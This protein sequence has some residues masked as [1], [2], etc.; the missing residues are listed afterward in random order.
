[1]LIFCYSH[2]ICRSE[3]I[4]KSTCWK[5]RCTEFLS[6]PRT[7]NK[8][9]KNGN[10]GRQNTSAINLSESHCINLNLN[11]KTHTN[12]IPAPDLSRSRHPSFN[13]N[14]TILTTRITRDEVNV[15]LSCRNPDSPEKIRCRDRR[16]R[17][18][19]NERACNDELHNESELLLTA[20]TWTACGITVGAGGTRRKRGHRGKD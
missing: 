16:R 9:K 18:K 3:S 1:M 5:S 17:K 13:K 19:K 10:K 7:T 11:M 12:S 14:I 6:V 20:D 8:N 2:E 15:S 4:S